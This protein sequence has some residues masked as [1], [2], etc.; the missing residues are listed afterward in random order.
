MR[1]N[2]KISSIFWKG[3]FTL[4][5]LYLTLYF[6][7]WLLESIEATF[8]QFLKAML[9]SYYVPGMGL[10]TALLI[11]FAIGL[12]LQI[13]ITQHLNHAL[14]KF[15]GKLPILGELYISLQSIIKYLTTPTKPARQEVVMV[16]F[17]NLNLNMLGIVTRTNFEASPAGIGDESLISV[18]IPMS[19][20]IGGFTIYVPKTSVTPV[21]L[22]AKEALKWAFMAGIES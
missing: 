14:N 5:P 3:L 20:Q 22:T 11:V 4:L 15:I 18:Y 6:L 21:D 10:L 9:G 7:W 17:E 1:L 16:H 13:Y 2:G 12:L 19:Y 8:S